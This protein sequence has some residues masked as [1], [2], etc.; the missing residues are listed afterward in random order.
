MIVYEHI[1]L[2]VCESV[3]AGVQA[4]S[5]ECKKSPF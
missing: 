1:S 4:S 5:I 2:C 3:W